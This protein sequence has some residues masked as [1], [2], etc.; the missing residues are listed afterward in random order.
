[1]KRAHLIC[2]THWDR[3]W[4]LTRM[5]FRPRLVRLVDSLL[6]LAE[7]C[8]DYVSFM[9]DAQTLT[10]ED[11]LEVKPYNR[12]WL[13]KAIESGKIT[14]GPWYIL[15]DEMLV[16]GESHIRNYLIGDAVAA[17]FGRKMEIGYLPDSFGH[18]AQMPQI[19]QGLG[20]DSNIFWRGTPH[21]MDQTEFYWT[22]PDG[23][24]QVLCVNMPLGYSSAAR[25]GSDVSRAVAQLQKA[26]GLLA[27]QG[28]TD[29]L[30][31]MNG[32]D[33][34]HADRHVPEIVREYNRT[35]ADSEVVFSTM[36]DFLA[37][38][39]A[40][41]PA[42]I[43]NHSGNLCYSDKVIL[44]GGTLST[45]VYLKQA[46]HRVQKKLERYV[47][48]LHS[49][50]QL[51][52]GNFDFGGYQ[53]YLWKLVLEN[54]PHDSICGCSV[55]PL[56]EEM[57]TRFTC[58][59]QLE[60]TMLAD[61]CERF[62][63][64]GD[65]GAD[66]QMMVFEPTQDRLPQYVEVEVD[67]DSICKHSMNYPVA[68]THELPG[69]LPPV[70]QGVRA[71]DENGAEVPAVLLSAWP[72]T[73]VMR[74]A[75]YDQPT[76]Y[77]VNRARV[78]LLLPGMDYGLHTLRICRDDS[79]TAPQ[80]VPA[81]GIENEFY[82]VA[83]D[84]QNASFIV[85]DK[86]A[87]VTHTGVH[88]FVDLGDAGDE[89]TYSW[90]DNDRLYTLDAGKV[91]SVEITAVGALS[92]S[93]TIHGVLQLPTGLTADRKARADDV[94]DCPFTVKATL[95]HGTD[96]IDFATHIENHAKDHRLQVEFPAGALCTHSSGSAAF[97]V[98]QHPIEHVIPEQWEEFPQSAMLNHGFADLGDGNCGVSLASNGIAEY[99][100]VNREGA[101]FLRLTLLR[102]VGWLSLS[103][104]NTR[105]IHGGWQCETP[106]AQCIGG[107]D[108]AYSI[109]YHQQGW[110]QAGTYAISERALHP[111]YLGQAFA[112]LAQKQNPL[113]FLSDLPQLIRLSAVKPSEDGNGIILR[114][115]SLADKVIDFSL[116]LPEAV[117]AAYAVTLAEKR[118]EELSCPGGNLSLSVKPGKIISIELQPK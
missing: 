32:S 111:A 100:A 98:T 4:Y 118:Q 72:D 94:I 11:Y 81:T 28:S 6:D 108:F 83:F 59:E 71:F 109:T 42:D 19:L 3:E 47:E 12:E 76:I 33:H 103:N 54:H 39:R 85:T 27:E 78:A 93:I 43:K 36:A 49:L 46:N 10:L 18:P 66:A 96:R 113:A 37:D 38:L 62:Q 84:K 102:S 87:G 104:L 101:S 63:Q 41:L 115:F 107:Y 73:Y 22:A 90:P 79:A 31:L 34:L 51:A 56:H 69:E 30:L 25:L 74:L 48:P 114:F 61:L 97:G 8:E 117:S 77:H 89:Y 64:P 60:D 92:Q 65:T 13:K 29:I 105:K 55:D 7:N 21:E 50:E 24:S 75:D 15:P 52:G 35:T 68:T 53:Q 57:M 112:S 88:R 23:E 80:S 17:Q 26:V 67:F 9:F 44:L 16:S 106:G 1:M 40:H 95:C 2:H 99:E 116:S 82:T 110:Q 70:P 58:L 86:K 45:R 5:E 20:L 14:I 91:E